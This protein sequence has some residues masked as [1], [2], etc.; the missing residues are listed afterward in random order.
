MLED[1]AIDVVDL[2][3]GFDEC[4]G[5]AHGLGFGRRVMIPACVHGDAGDEGIRHFGRDGGFEGL[6]G[7]EDE[8]AAGLGGGVFE[9]GRAEVV[10]GDVVI[11]DDARAFEI[12]DD[13]GHIAEL[14]PGGE[15][16][17]DDGL[18]IGEIGGLHGCAEVFEEG[19]VWIE[20]G[21]SG[22]RSAGVDDSDVL[23]ALFEQTCDADF[24][25]ERV[26]IGPDVGC[27]EETIA[28]GDGLFEGCPIDGH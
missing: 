4:R 16:A 28:G 5:I 26:A 17:D 20:I 11:D 25:A 1:L 12:A 3:A 22:G 2:G 14:S 19:V 7:A 24:G 21:V 13:I 10:L 8:G 15:V 6:G 9:H 23:A 27:D 18:A